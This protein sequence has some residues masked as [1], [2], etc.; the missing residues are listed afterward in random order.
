[1]P[2]KAVGQAAVEL[3]WLCPRTDSLIALADAPASVL[4]AAVT[5][6]ALELFLLRF[7]QLSGEPDPFGFA[8]GA[9]HSSF[10]PETAAAFLTATRAG[11]I[12][13]DSHVVGRVRRIAERAAAIAMELADT[14]RLVPAPVAG[15]L[16][17]LAP[18]GWYAVAAVDPF[19]AAEPLADPNFPAHSVEVQAEVW[20]LDHPAITRRLCARWRLPAWVGETIAALNLPLNLAAD[21][22]VNRDL[23]AI[24]QLA[25]MGAESDGDTLGL[26]GGAQRGD[27]LD[28]LRLDDR[29]VDRARSTS[30]ESPSQKGS[31]LQSNPHQVPLVRNLL[32]VAGESRRRNGPGLV[33]RLEARIDELH[34]IV[35]HLGEQVGERLRDAKLAGLAEL[36][37]GAGHEINNPL[38]IISSNAQRMLRLES[39]PSRSEPLQAIVRQA[40]RIAGLL[41]DLMHF[42]RPP[43]PKQH[44]FLANELLLSIR[45]DFQLIAD[46]RNIRLEVAH[47]PPDL[48]V[49]ADQQQLRRAL[50]AVVLNGIEAASEQGWVRVLHGEDSE[51]VITFTI[52]DSGSGLTADAAEHAFDPFY[53]GRTAGR[54]RGLGLAT[55]WRLARQNGGDLRFDPTA[56]PVTRFILT[57]TRAVGCE[58]LPL[59]SA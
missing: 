30:R 13:E 37:A 52:E 7:A 22:V 12:P 18:L 29:A 10:L 24:V 8:P 49:L 51:A 47:S 55:A 50:G 17:R 11:V 59:K 9:L 36:A 44:A 25:V 14:T 15:S 21:L 6:P 2:G 38:A 42:A 26:T 45:D 33:S 58:L 35:E 5:D 4:G 3:P 1:V 48:W 19:D 32:R 20:G 23:F 54:G 46:E 56:A 57:A 41:R 53:C 27:L 43:A 34:R 40:N 31:G 39:D 28:Y 16:A